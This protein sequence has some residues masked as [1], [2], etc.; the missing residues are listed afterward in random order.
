MEPIPARP[1]VLDPF[2]PRADVSERHETVVHAAQHVVYEAARTLDPRSVLPARVLFWLR[3]RLLAGKRPGS[4]PW[5]AGLIDGALTAGW[6][7]LLVEE[8]RVFVAGAVCRPWMPG[9]PLTTVPPERFVFFCD[10]DMVKVAW[11]VEAERLGEMLSWLTVEIRAVGTDPDARGRLLQHWRAFGLGASALCRMVVPAIRR[12]A[13]RR[14]PCRSLEPESENED[15]AASLRSDDAPEGQ[16]PHAG[17]PPAA[18][19]PQ[20]GSPASRID[21]PRSSSR[22]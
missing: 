3:A 16:A 4:N 19:S 9:A 14:W 15:L 2:I 22:K 20:A 12:S 5:S 6:G 7:R 13:E 8:G 18:S 1:S 21:A 17:R 10:H 11:S